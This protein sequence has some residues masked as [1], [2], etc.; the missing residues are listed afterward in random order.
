MKLLVLGATCLTG[1]FVVKQAL[2]AGHTLV[3][4]VR[5]QKKVPSGL[6]NPQNLTV[7]EDDLSNASARLKS[8]LPTFDAIISLLG[9]TGGE[10]YVGTAITQFYIALRADLRQ[11][12]ASQRPYLLVM[13]T[14]SI[15]DAND[16]FSLFTR[17]H[18][19]TIKNLMRAVRA[20]IIG[21]GK[22]FQDDLANESK[23]DEKDRLDWCV[24]RLNLLKDYG[25]PVEGHRAGYVGKGDWI[26][27]VDRA[28]LAAWLIEEAK[29]RRWVRKMPA[30]W[31]IDSNEK[32]F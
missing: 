20:E 14:Q 28:Q 22:L 4:Y 24:Y 5:N 17:V 29:E 11:L 1:H 9:P 15:F 19:L 12:P 30:V 32:Q 27:T 13:G 26:A 18:I 6:E 23:E 3:I 10:K 16:G 31:G 7:I 2:A 8:E 25:L 21:M